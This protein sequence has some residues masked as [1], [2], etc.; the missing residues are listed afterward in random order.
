MIGYPRTKVR[1]A[2]GIAGWETL[3][4]DIYRWGWGALQL[5]ETEAEKAQESGGVE[6]SR[7]ARKSE[8]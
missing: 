4:P 7:V 6:L 2:H 8:K 1:G 5:E 3:E